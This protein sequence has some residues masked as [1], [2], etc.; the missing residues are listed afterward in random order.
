[1]A[2]S[3]RDGV[4][5]WA[6]ADTA[7]SNSDETVK[8]IMDFMLVVFDQRMWLWVRLCC[9]IESRRL[10]AIDLVSRCYTRAPLY[11]LA[12]SEDIKDRS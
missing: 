11:E 8:E 7:A 4:G 5:A 3:T 9:C 10:S 2:L 1:M 12:S 6:R